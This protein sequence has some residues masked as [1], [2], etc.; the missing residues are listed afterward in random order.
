MAP[1]HTHS[2][3]SAE[4]DEAA[5]RRDLSASVIRR[6]IGLM[7]FLA[8]MFALLGVHVMGAVLCACG[9]LFALCSAW[10]RRGLT[11]RARVGFFLGSNV[12]LVA[13]ALYAGYEARVH[14]PLLS[15]LLLAFILFSPDERA[16]RRV[17][18]SLSCAGFAGIELAH[19][20]FGL[21]GSL[22][23]ALQHRIW[24][25]TVV[26]T[27]IEFVTRSRL[28]YDSNQRSEARL[29]AAL[30]DALHAR[31]EALAASRVKSQ[32]LAN[33]SHEI[34]TP[35]NGILGAA[36]LLGESPLAPEQRE[37]VEVLQQS[38]QGLLGVIDD[39][40]DLSKIEAGRLDLEAV[41][42][43][44]ADVVEAARAPIAPQAARKGISLTVSVAP[45]LALWRRGDPT[46]LRQ[47]LLNLLGNAVKFTEA[48]AVTLRVEAG[49]GA[50]AVRFTVDDT[51]IGIS[52]E[53]VAG[54]FEAFTQA[55]GST[56]RR[57]GGTGLGLT[58]SR[59]LVARM[60]GALTVTSAVGVGSSFAFTAS[61]P[62]CE[63]PTGRVVRL[64]A[65]PAR[66]LSLLLAED[67]A[68]N[69]RIMTRVLE[70]LGHG[71]THAANGALALARLG[72]G[73]GFDAVLMD[74]Q[75]P[76]LDGL[77]ATR[78][79]RAD[80]AREGRPRVPVI[81]LTAH[82]M[83]GDD[84]TCRAAGM[85]SYLSKPIDPLR[86]RESLDAVSSRA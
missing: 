64:S 10:M 13:M 2:P 4:L 49:D 39:V 31:E 60:G 32:F 47:V 1:T 23:P 9:A 30:D 70:G 72:P 11:L 26:G 56:T 19:N 74:V 45:G 20:L 54:V 29:R 84:E 65:A 73:H 40:L 51:G 68:V 3:L 7:A 34:R 18:V 50:D 53:R 78:R 76:E 14:Y 86:L 24:V 55:D 25:I 28:L 21:P 75:M 80:E 46:R 41:P 43:S 67:N 69:V 58:I 12:G 48:G 57:Y 5:R 35:M 42:L 52:P 79:L 63:A 83:K 77:E 61:L 8:P 27:L 36:V 33:T 15:Q 44:L 37:Y 6:G 38:A 85:D 16:A 59:E 81:A 62:P 82:A 71:V 66:R 22:S 17:A